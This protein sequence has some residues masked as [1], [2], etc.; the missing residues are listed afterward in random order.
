ML[1]LHHIEQPALALRQAARCLKPGGTILVVDL[2]P[3]DHEEFRHRM[4]HAHLGFSQAD[5][6]GYAVAAGLRL[7][8][9]HRLRPDTHSRGPGLFAGVLAKPAKA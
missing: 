6:T 3:H 8:R 2:A 7:V 9:W 5:L 1:V 4:G